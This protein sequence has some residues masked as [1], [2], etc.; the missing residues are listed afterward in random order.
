MRKKRIFTWRSQSLVVTQFP[1]GRGGSSGDSNTGSESDSGNIPHLHLKTY[2]KG[3]ER[4]DA[5]NNPFGFLYTKFD[6]EDG[7]VIRDC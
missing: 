2:V 6:S 4:D 7:N 5:T 1:W 3:T